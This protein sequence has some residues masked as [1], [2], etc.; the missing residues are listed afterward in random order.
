MGRFIGMGRYNPPEPMDSGS[1]ARR[2]RIHEASARF[3]DRGI[4]LTFGM[5]R[6]RSKAQ[7]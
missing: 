5:L 1:S 4:P 2:V 6:A 3:S 7:I